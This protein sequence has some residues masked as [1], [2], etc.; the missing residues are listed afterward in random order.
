[1]DGIRA[2]PRSLQLVMD[3]SVDANLH[4]VQVRILIFSLRMHS[5]SGFSTLTV[6][7][8]TIRTLAL[9]VYP[10]PQS[11]PS[12]FWQAPQCLLEVT[13]LPNKTPV[14]RL[15]CNTRARGEALPKGPLLQVNT[16][17]GR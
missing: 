16:Q 3:V 11:P 13:M 1:M 12:L 17:D 6:R 5:P 2:V 10:T 14:L 9:M 7:T 8:P 4:A 15:R